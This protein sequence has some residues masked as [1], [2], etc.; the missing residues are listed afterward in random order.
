MNKISHF[1]F[2]ALIFMMGCAGKNVLVTSDSIRTVKKL[3]VGMVELSSHGFD[4]AAFYDCMKDYPSAW[5]GMDSQT[6]RDLEA[7]GWMMDNLVGSLQKQDFETYKNIKNFSLL[8]LLFKNKE[9]K[10]FIR[11]VNFLSK[12]VRTLSISS[13]QFTC[14]NI[15]AS[16]KLIAVDSIPPFADVYINDRKIGEAPIWT[17]LEN[18]NYDLQCKLPDD[19]FSKTSLQVP[20]HVKFLCKRQN[21]TM[22]GIETSTDENA[23][24]D[25][26]AGSWFLYTVAGI[27]TLGGA[28]LPFL[29]F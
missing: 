24:A 17:S 5:V 10:N 20:G 6:Q 21:Q 15:L 16:A 4:T 8:L 28:V 18:G 19:A 29:L 26:K 9:Q 13:D 7:D 23:D 1:F 14:E 27:F 3:R 25:E 22:L 2:L 11:T 12:Q